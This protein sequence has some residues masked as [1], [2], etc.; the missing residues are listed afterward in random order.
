MSF[1][2][3]AC[4]FNNRLH[5]FDASLD[6]LVQ[7]SFINLWETQEVNRSGIACSWVHGNVLLQCLVDVF[8]E[9]WCI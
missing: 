8:C 9:E 4:Q 3:I 6:F 5:S 1:S 2:D 7:V